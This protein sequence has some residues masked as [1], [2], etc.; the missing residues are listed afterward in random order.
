MKENPLEQHILGTYLSLRYGLAVIAFSFPVI[1]WIG[2][3]YYA[4]VGLQDSMSAY[5][6]ACTGGRS[7][8]IWFAGILLVVGA[9]L[10][11]YKGYRQAED[12]ALNCA[13]V[14]AIGIA[15]FP[16]DWTAKTS[17]ITDESEVCACLQGIPLT[18]DGTSVH[19]YLH[20][21]CAISFFLCIAFVCLFCASD[22]LPLIKDK[23]KEDM[24]RRKY[25]AAG[26]AMIVSPITAFIL[27][28]MLGKYN[29]FI[30]VVEV[31][32]IYAFAFYWL[33]KSREIKETNAELHAIRGELTRIVRPRVGVDEVKVVHSTDL[34]PQAGRPRE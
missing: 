22:T 27:T 8:R 26:T 20:G 24:Y 10:Y 2:G 25:H 28:Q 14:L 19:A 6:Y 23:P 21:F 32:G 11:L 16:M 1:L 17:R 33:I 31:L 7:M 15:L 18:I 4:D 9:C 34:A 12:I 5:Y 3:R 30:F 29:W 13:G